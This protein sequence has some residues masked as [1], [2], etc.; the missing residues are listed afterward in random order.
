MKIIL[1]FSL[2]CF[3][4]LSVV[5][6]NESPKNP[7]DNDNHKTECLKTRE[8]AAADFKKGIRKVYLFGLVDDYKYRQ[9]LTDKHGIDARYM[10]CLVTDELRC[11]SD[12]MEEMIAQERGFGF[13]EK[14][15]VETGS[16]AMPFKSV[17]KS[18]AN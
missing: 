3:S 12:F 16:K 2:V 10:G 15:R 14:V 13:F 9:V 11:Y 1:T 6:Q 5:A 8:Q 7:T 4:L 18:F 17:F